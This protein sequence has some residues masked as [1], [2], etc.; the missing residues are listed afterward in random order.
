MCCICSN[1]QMFT[2]FRL[3]N[4]KHVL[5]C[6]FPYS[7]SNFI[8]LHILLF[9]L[10]ICVLSFFS[11]LEIYRIRSDFPTTK[12]VL[13][14]KYVLSSKKKHSWSCRSK[15]VQTQQHLRQVHDDVWHFS[16]KIQKHQPQLLLCFLVVLVCYFHTA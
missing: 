5:I 11:G 2:F 15:N 7:Y 12:P 1:V 6:V 10:Y 4:N 14:A 8:I 16:A 9:N 3:L 13:P